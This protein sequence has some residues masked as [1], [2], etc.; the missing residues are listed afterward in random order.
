[1]A[2]YDNIKGQGFHTNPERINK[3]GRPRKTYKKI[4]REYKK[5]GLR[6]PSKEDYFDFLGVLLSMTEEDMRNIMK[7]KDLPQ[8]QRWLIKD[9]GDAGQRRLIMQEILDR[10]FG[11]AN[12]ALD[13]TSDGEKIKVNIIVDE[14]TKP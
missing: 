9:L 13:V 3:K 6:A 11:K 12:Q 8:W 7:D 2:G 5:L 1:M 4:N 10:L 14:D